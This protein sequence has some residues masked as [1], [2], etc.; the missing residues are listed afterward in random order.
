ML[1]VISVLLAATGCRSV[2]PEKIPDATDAIAGLSCHRDATA[3]KKSSSAFRICHRE[4][5]TWQVACQWLNDL[6]RVMPQVAIVHR[7]AYATH[8]AI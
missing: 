4:P 3:L 5:T 8:L 6:T 2:R 7:V 1:M